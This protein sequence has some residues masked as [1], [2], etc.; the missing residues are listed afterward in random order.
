MAGDIT[1][2]DIWPLVPSVVSHET[3]NHVACK[4]DKMADEDILFWQSALTR[5][6]L[7]EEIL[8]T[9]IQTQFQDWCRDTYKGGRI[10]RK[11]V[12]LF[13]DVNG[14]MASQRLSGRPL[15]ASTFE[16]KEKIV[17]VEGENN[18]MT[19]RKIAA[20]NGKRALCS[21]GY[22]GKCLVRRM[23]FLPPLGPS[24]VDDGAQD[25]AKK[26]SPQKCLEKMWRRSL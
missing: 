18:S 20:E 2:R 7:E 6:L 19:T 11:W 23:V 22:G 3:E 26:Y 16:N 1:I 5:F 8:T 24:I 13:K 12:K 9:G 15:S 4:Y 25:S 14:D 21:P 10:V 17:E